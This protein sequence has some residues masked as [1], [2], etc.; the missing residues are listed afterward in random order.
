MKRFSLLFTVL[1]LCALKFNTPIFAQD[2]LV[3]QG[4]VFIAN[5]GTPL[6][7]VQLDIRADGKLI[8]FK[9]S[10]QQGNFRFV[11]LA[12]RSYQLEAK[13][14]GFQP[15]V[16][17]FTIEADKIT[18]LDVALKMGHWV[19]FE[20]LSSDGKELKDVNPSLIGGTVKQTNGKPIKDA[21]V[22]LV[23]L[24]S[25]DESIETL[26]N[27]KGEFSFHAVEGQFVIYVYKRGYRAQSDT[28]M[29][30]H[31]SYGFSK[32][33]TLKTMDER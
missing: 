3:L 10:D 1:F 12:A 19:H 4:Q 13:L 15:K 32:I 21:H 2:N 31:P 25:N 5:Y 23:S 6:A 7:D 30:S 8:N 18:N 29:L 24:F 33:F 26:T 20:I 17:A 28:F 11:G 27:S 22:V 14:A 9:K 16:I